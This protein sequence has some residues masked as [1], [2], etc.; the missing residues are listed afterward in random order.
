[1]VTDE[2]RPGYAVATLRSRKFMVFR[3]RLAQ[4]LGSRRTESFSHQGFSGDGES[5]TFTVLR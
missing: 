5:P 1:M 3:Q 2:S 4:S